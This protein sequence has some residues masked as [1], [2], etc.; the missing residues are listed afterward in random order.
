M[1]LPP[2][3]AVDDLPHPALGLRQKINLVFS[4]LALLVLGVLVALQI[5]TA[6]AGVREEIDASNRIAVQLLDRVT[7]LHALGGLAALTAFLSE[8]GRIRANDVVLTD[9][10]GRVLYTS[11]PSLYK[12]G[13]DAPAWYAALVTPSLRP[14]TLTL[15]SGR[16]RITANPTRSVLDA[17]DDLRRVVLVQALLLLGADLLLLWMVGRWLLPLE[18]IGDGLRAIER[19]RHQSRLP[20]LAG[21][22]AGALGRTFNRMAQALEDNFEM[23]RREAESQAR[24]AAQREFTALLERR[25]EEERAALARE[26]HDAFGQS[27]TAIRS[28]AKALL[29]DP[30]IAGRPSAR[31]VAMVYDSAGATAD[32]LQRM[33]PRLRP[34]QLD[35][36]GLAEALADL[37][38]ELRLANP[39]LQIE[40][41]CAGQLP[42]L[43]DAAELSLYR[44]VQEALTNVVRHAGAGR[45][46]VELRRDGD[47]LRLTVLDDGIG[48]ASLVRDGHYGVRGMQ[49]RVAA[50]EGSIVFG[51]GP[52]GGLRIDVALDLRR[53]A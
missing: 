38:A 27:L 26:L 21:K 46:Q 22:E 2:A 20:P 13:R 24:L 40:L 23:R 1:S 30:D 43:G 53:L 16:L 28:I 19:G 44:I 5:Q 51:P 45:A 11:P 6:R 37:S 36:M 12:A 15:R 41:A 48:A 18:S 17:W 7:R 4:A 49:E 50:L 9:P 31:A 14:I 47:T 8:T 25:I 10:A 34:I 29:A 39:A 3:A 42:P 33:I 32:A 35:G 52:D